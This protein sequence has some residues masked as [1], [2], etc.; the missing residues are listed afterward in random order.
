MLWCRPVGVF[1]A[2]EIKGKRALVARPED[3][4]YIVP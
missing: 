3:M 2:E 1:D 4:H